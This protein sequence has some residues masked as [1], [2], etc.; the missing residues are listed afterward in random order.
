M[1]GDCDVPSNNHLKAL[2]PQEQAEEIHVLFAFF[3]EDNTKDAAHSH[4]RDT[5]NKYGLK[6]SVVGNQD[7]E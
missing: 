6:T 3:V 4:L 5:Q 2:A 1:N 7:E